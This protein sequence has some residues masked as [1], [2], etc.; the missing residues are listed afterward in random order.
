MPKVTIDI[1][2]D[3]R[4]VNLLSSNRPVPK[5][6]QRA[7]TAIGNDIAQ[8]AKSLA[9]VDTGA[10]RSSISSKFSTTPLARSIVVA[11]VAYAQFVH[12]GRRPGSPPPTA[13]VAGWARRKGLNPYLVARAIGRRGIKG[14]PFFT[15]AVKKIVTQVSNHLRV[16][17]SEIERDWKA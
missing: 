4:L 11:N 16:A 15:D 3:S 12:D 6:V 13:A 2:G 9:P 5:P 17:V 10:L 14:R 7:V 1:A 8:E